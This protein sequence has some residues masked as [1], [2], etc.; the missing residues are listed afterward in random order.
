MD[1]HG[2]LTSREAT[3]RLRGEK[4]P[5]DYGIAGEATA[6]ALTKNGRKATTPPTGVSEPVVSITRATTRIQIDVS[7]VCNDPAAHIRSRGSEH[8]K[9]GG[10]DGNTTC[11]ACVLAKQLREVQWEARRA[12]NAA[13]RLLYRVDSGVVDRSI[14]DRGRPPKGAEWSEIAV[15]HV[16]AAIGIELAPMVSDL[17]KQATSGKRYVYLYPFVR[18]IS[19]EI[20]AGMASAIARQVEQRWR[21]DRWDVLVRESKSPPHFTDTYPMPVR[22][23]DSSLA[24]LGGDEYELS[25]SLRS[26]RGQGW[27]IPIKA[28]DD[29]MRHVLRTLTSGNAKIGQLFLTPDRLRPG[30]WYARI[31]YTK[32]VQA[33]PKQ[34]VVLAVRP[35]MVALITAVT[36][37]GRYW[38]FYGDDIE[39]HLDVIQAQRR[40]LQGTSKVS[41][42]VGHGRNRT[43]QPTQRLRMGHE[44]WV[45]TWIRTRMAR[46]VEWALA[47]GVVKVFM[48]DFSGIRDT[49]PEKLKW[50]KWVWDRIQEWPRYRIQQTLIGLFEEHGIQ[51]VAGIDPEHGC[52]QC[53]ATGESV[54]VDISRKKRR[55]VCKHCGYKQQLDLA[56]VQMCLRRGEQLNGSE[57][58][59]PAS[60]RKHSG[61]RSGRKRKK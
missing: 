47:E 37:T 43:L 5:A 50:G 57:P 51:V 3:A 32:Q 16:R 34:G 41:G 54:S 46:L 29:H 27:R 44:R 38:S 56:L 17:V 58:P 35:G 20:T 23:Q 7:R 33:A 10:D 14:L 59:K 49:A 4:A 30:R 22:A 40:R 15:E 39:H 24:H 2:S 48:P 13:L 8:C 45:D 25:F 11:L 9:G 42:R 19:P 52:S 21:Q 53:G 31:S 6:G 55:L 12:A 28:R 26:G 61:G 60:S 36:S 1:T 18:K